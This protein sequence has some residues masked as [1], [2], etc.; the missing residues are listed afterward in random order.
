[1]CVLFSAQHNKVSDKSFLSY[2]KS[3][4]LLDDGQQPGS[5][6]QGKL[7]KTTNPEGWYLLFS[8]KLRKK[9]G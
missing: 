1:M 9:Y 2:V 4:H 8:I 7:L 5:S 3:A 6:F